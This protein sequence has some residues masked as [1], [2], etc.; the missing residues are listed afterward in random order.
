MIGSKASKLEDSY[1]N[2]SEFETLLDD[3]DMQAS[4][5]SEVDFVEQS[6]EKYRKWGGTMFW[7]DKQDT[8]LRKIGG[9]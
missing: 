9:E 3:A 1:T 5:E 4:T 2:L 8:W 6:K 7:S